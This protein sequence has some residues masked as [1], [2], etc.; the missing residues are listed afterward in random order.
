MT[1][2]GR[3]AAAPVRPDDADIQSILQ[4]T[5]ANQTEL[6]TWI[7]RLGLSALWRSVREPNTEP[8]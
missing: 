5:S 6:T 8:Q 7:D 1:G 4:T 2:S 3:R